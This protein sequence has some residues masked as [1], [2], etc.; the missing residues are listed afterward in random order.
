[1]NGNMFHE[2][3]RKSARFMG[4]VRAGGWVQAE[5]LCRWLNRT[6]G[7]EPDKDRAVMLEALRL[8][9]EMEMKGFPSGGPVYPD[10][11]RRGIALRKAWRSLRT[12][13]DK[14]PPMKWAVNP[15]GWGYVLQLEHNGP[16]SF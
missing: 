10:G 13:L 2:N 6:P 3:H 1:M 9:R 5:N 15:V 12:I 8:L 4:M 11:S 16:L 7:F 14:L